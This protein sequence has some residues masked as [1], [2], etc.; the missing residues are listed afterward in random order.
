MTRSNHRL[1]A[2]PYLIEVNGDDR[3]D[4]LSYDAN[5]GAC[6]LARN[7]TNGSFAYTSGTWAQHLS[8]VVRPNLR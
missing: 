1:G 2:I 7:L 3:A 8:I 5:T 4:V 6:Q